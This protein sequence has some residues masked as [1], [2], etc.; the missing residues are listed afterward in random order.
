MVHKVLSKIDG[1]QDKVEC[2][3]N[4]KAGKGIGSSG[5]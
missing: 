5:V 1:M 3:E 2:V 4:V